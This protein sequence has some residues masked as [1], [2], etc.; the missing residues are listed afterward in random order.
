MND[1]NMSSR[2]YLR[3][4]QP[5]WAKFCLTNVLFMQKN[6]N[7]YEI[8][9]KKMDE[10][11]V[12][13]DN[14]LKCCW[15]IVWFCALPEHLISTAEYMC[16]HLQLQLLGPKFI[17]PTSFIASICLHDIH[18]ICSLNVLNAR[19][20]CPHFV[21]NQKCVA[22]IFEFWWLLLFCDIIFC[23]YFKCCCVK[24]RKFSQFYSLVAANYSWFNW[25]I[26]Q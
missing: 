24:T 4:R 10:K 26:S 1:V 18:F 25:L 11:V 17:M 15:K 20:F 13:D 22:S 8:D 16:F 3:Q 14:W 19:V 9:A 23:V 2:H 5:N 7:L 21:S 6:V 12:L